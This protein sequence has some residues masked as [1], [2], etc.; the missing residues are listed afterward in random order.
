METLARRLARPAVCAGLVVALAGCGASLQLSGGH[1]PTQY[2]DD[3]GPYPPPSLPVGVTVAVVDA[4]ESGLAPTYIVETP[5]GSIHSSQIPE[6]GPPRPASLGVPIPEGFAPAAASLAA[7]PP[8]DDAEIV[9]GSFSA[10][11]TT[12]F[13]TNGFNTGFLFV[14]PDPMA[15]AGPTR[16]VATTNVTIRFHDKNGS[17]LLDTSLRNFFA[18]LGP[19]TF[20]FDPKVIYD[21]EDGRFVVVTLERT[22]TALGQ[23]ANS[24]R[25]LIAVSDDDDPAGLWYQAAINSMTMIGGTNHWADYP[26]LAVDEEAVYITNNMFTFGAAP[27]Y[28]GARLW[29]LDKGLTTGGLYAGGALTFGVYDPYAAGGWPLTTQPAHVFTPSP[30]GVGTLLVAYGGLTDG[31]NEYLQTI[32]LDSP[33]TAPT[34]T[35]L[36]YPFLGDIEDT[37]LAMQDAPQPISGWHIE[38]ND[39]RALDAV[40]RADALWMT[41]QIVPWTFDPEAGQATAFWAEL[42]TSNLALLMALDQGRISGEDI[43]P[44]PTTEVYTYYPAIAVNAFGHAAIGFAAS[45]INVFAGAYFVTHRPSDPPGTVS[46]SN[47]LA[48]GM[49]FYER[50]F[51]A[52][53]NRLGDYTGMEVDPADQCF[54]VFNEFA[55][56]R[57]NPTTPPMPPEDGR[58][59]TMVGRFCSCDGNEASGDSDLDATCDDID[60]CP[61]ITNPGQADGDLDTVGDVCDNC[62]AVPNPAQLDGDTD[63]VGDQCD[64]CPAAPNPGQADGDVDTVGDVCDNCPAVPNPAQLDGDIRHGG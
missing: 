43:D 31:T 45:S 4:V 61:L 34:F 25:I 64:N 60:N 22:D 5:P 57:G 20:T 41:T 18:G 42:D 44:A 35:N 33:L 15:A 6:V 40:W 37:T 28:G 27:T 59:G 39:R 52:G 11:P 48:P 24:S 12:D 8:G 62:P 26:G 17:L 63:T 46:G 55:S 49:D 56:V 10:F 3:P 54:W 30:A 38:T 21:Q 53:R 1:A 32:E 13:D 7:G 36:Q 16:I 58:W 23:P 51:G 9:A 2:P 19:Q 47:L 14:P 29:V 50:T